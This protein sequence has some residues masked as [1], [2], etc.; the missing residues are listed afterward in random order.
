MRLPLFAALLLVGCKTAEPVPEALSDK[1][2]ATGEIA[3]QGVGASFDQNRVVGPLVNLTRRT[4]GSW[5]G[6]LRDEPMDV[7]VYAARV[8]GVN[9]TMAWEPSADGGTAITGQW[10]GGIMRFETSGDTL[11]IRTPRHSLTMNRHDASS[12]GP[13]GELVLKGEAGLKTP[14]MPQFG[15]AMMAAF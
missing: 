10:N 1:F 4:D 14:P 3:Y 12:F 15:F 9:F 6:R 5:G 8:T 13:F 2:T 7:S 11:L